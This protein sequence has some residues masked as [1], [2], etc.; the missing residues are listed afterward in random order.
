VAEVAAAGRAAILVPWA[1]A[2]DD[3]QSLNAAPFRAL[4]AAHVIGDAELTAA[5]LRDEVDA[6]L[7]DDA[8]R[9]GME[10]AMRALARPEAAAEMAG[11]LLAL[12]RR[13]AA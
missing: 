5:G 11:I 13:E 1:G 8:R 3:H 12:A 2:A 9:H 7:A 10:Q 4:G 6:I